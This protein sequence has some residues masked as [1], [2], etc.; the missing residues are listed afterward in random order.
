MVELLKVPLRRGGT[1]PLR[2][3][4]GAR[5]ALDQDE[6]REGGGSER[7]EGPDLE[8]DSRLSQ[9]GEAREPRDATGRWRTDGSD[10]DSVLRDERRRAGSEGE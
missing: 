4:A 1:D 8:E 5:G 6:G 2:R 3:T 10:Y 9:E 7:E